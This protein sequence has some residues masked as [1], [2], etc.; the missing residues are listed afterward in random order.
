MKGGVMKEDVKKFVDQATQ[1]CWDIS[2]SVS[3]KKLT[4]HFGVNDLDKITKP[5][6]E[7]CLELY[8]RIFTIEKPD[9]VL[10]GMENQA[11]EDVLDLLVGRVRMN[12]P[13]GLDH[14]FMKNWLKP[15]TDHI[16]K[17]AKIIKKGAKYNDTAYKAMRFSE[18]ESETGKRELLEGLKKAIFAEGLSVHGVLDIIAK[19]LNEPGPFEFYGN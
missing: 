2:C 18:K 12:G 15:L 9:G 13:P 6:Q 3:D 17:Q 1:S 7:K 19:K 10:E 4:K 14:K 5:L 16:R 11:I 8:S